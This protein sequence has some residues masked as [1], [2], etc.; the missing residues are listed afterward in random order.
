M[1]T[2]SIWIQVQLTTIV[3][4][5]V[6]CG[7]YQVT[8]YT[9]YGKTGAVKTKYETQPVKGE[10]FIVEDNQLN[11]TAQVPILLSKTKEYIKDYEALKAIWE[12]LHGKEWSFYGDATFK[13]ANWNFNKELDMWGEQPGVTLN[14]NGRVI[15]LV[16]AGFG[17]KGIVPKCHRTAD[18]TP[19][20]QPRFSR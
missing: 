12:S 5:L 19:G 6:T 8:S 11:D 18:R 4:Y 10:A 3:P 17:A 20:A 9:T 16:I 14:S 15:G 2:I 13:G 7:T 1:R